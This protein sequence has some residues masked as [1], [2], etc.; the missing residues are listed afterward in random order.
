MPIHLLILAPLPTERG[1]YQALG[2]V[3]RFTDKCTRS[4]I[5]DIEPFDKTAEATAAGILGD[6]TD[7]L[8][9]EK[10]DKRKKKAKKAKEPADPKN[11]AMQ[12]PEQSAEQEILK[13]GQEQEWFPANADSE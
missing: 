6:L 5:E 11:V 2:R 10:A 3:G 4:I 9:E 8:I 1:Y 13:L 12:E 7:K